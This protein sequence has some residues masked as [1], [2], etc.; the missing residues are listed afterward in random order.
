MPVLMATVS[1]SD[2]KKT[3]GFSS[4]VLPAACTYRV[5]PLSGGYNVTGRQPGCGRDFAR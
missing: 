1:H 5:R 3:L 2:W 4:A